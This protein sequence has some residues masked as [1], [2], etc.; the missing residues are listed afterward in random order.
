MTHGTGADG[1][2]LNSAW[3]LKLHQTF[4][5]LARFYVENLSVSGR[6]AE[7]VWAADWARGNG[8]FS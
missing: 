2:Q 8:R 1:I 3:K 5:G 4:P 7:E 6:T